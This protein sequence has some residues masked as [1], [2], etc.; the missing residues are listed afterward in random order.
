MSN[1]RVFILV[2]GVWFE[3]QL[4]DRKLYSYYNMGEIGNNLGLIQNEFF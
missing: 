3:L 2:F 4:L 1:N